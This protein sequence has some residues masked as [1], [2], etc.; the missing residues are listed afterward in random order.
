ME[1]GHPILIRK[2]G[3]TI[4]VFSPEVHRNPLHAFLARVPTNHPSYPLLH[5]IK[6]NQSAGRHGEEK[7]LSSLREALHLQSA[8]VLHDF[9]M[10]IPNAY[11]IQIDFIVFTKSCILLLEVKNIKGTIRFQQYPAQLVR[12]LDGITQA[13]DCPFTQMTRNAFQFKKLLGSQSLPVFSAVVW[14]NRSAIIDP[15]SFEAPHPLLFLKQLPDYISKLPKEE[16]EGISLQRLVKRIQSKATPFFQTNLCER[17]GVLPQELM[18]GYICLSCY[19]KLRLHVRSWSCPNC[20]ILNKTC[21]KSNIMDVFDLKGD[22]LT[23][24]EIRSTIGEVSKRQLKELV[25]AGN[26]MMT[27]ASRNRR[28][29]VNRDLSVT[30][31]EMK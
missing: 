30:W 1:E 20:K 29:Q 18:R 27:G 7:V 2:G 3:I 25:E 26:L 8:T 15:L 5:S 10:R 19:E 16:A 12:T 21:L 24:Q 14:A 17:Y 6:T 23:S 11:A 31:S 22:M 28:Y 9:H 4:K 13:M